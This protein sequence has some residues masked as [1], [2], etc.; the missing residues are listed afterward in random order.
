MHPFI[1]HVFCLI[2]ALSIQARGKNALYTGPL[3]YI[4]DY[5]CAD[6]SYLGA[7]KV[8]PRAVRSTEYGVLH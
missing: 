1:Y 4:A 7:T 8:L 6:K 5:F 2:G 3:S